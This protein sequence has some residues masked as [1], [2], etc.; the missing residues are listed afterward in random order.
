MNKCLWP[1]HIWC[2]VLVA[3]LQCQQNTSYR[4]GILFLARP[5][6]YPQAM[7]NHGIVPPEGYSSMAKGAKNTRPLVSAQAVK[8]GPVGPE[9]R[10]DQGMSGPA[11]H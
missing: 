8:H 2:N 7:K 1:L 11:S 5:Q 9:G 4:T 3:Y 6:T 10:L